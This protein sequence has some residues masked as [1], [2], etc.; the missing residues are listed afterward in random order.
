[1]LNATAMAL[2]GEA[3]IYLGAFLGFAIPDLFFRLFRKICG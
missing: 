3:P 1:M 2:Q